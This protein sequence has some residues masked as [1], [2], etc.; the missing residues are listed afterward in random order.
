MGSQQRAVFPTGEF[1]PENGG[2]GEGAAEWWEAHTVTGLAWGRA[3]ERQGGT[4]GLPHSSHPLP[5]LLLSWPLSLP[6]C[7]PPASRREHPPWSIPE[8]ALPG[9]HFWDNSTLWGLTPCQ[10]PPTRPD[11]LWLGEAGPQ[12]APSQCP[13]PWRV[14]E[15]DSWA[16]P[17]P[18]PHRRA[19]PTPSPRAPL[20]GQADVPGRLP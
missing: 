3:L 12:P 9:L 18:L 13:A 2:R 8:R 7:P 15:G 17:C 5:S 14:Q 1:P 20:M 16:A 11:S 10:L 4:R 19:T 6:P